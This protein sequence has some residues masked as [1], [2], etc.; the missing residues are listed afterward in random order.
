MSNEISTWER[1]SA[2]YKGKKKKKKIRPLKN[3]IFN[4]S[5]AKV[6]EDCDFGLPESI[7][8]IS[9]E[10]KISPPQSIFCHSL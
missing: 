4:Q 1:E 3:C 10:G 2:A 9:G 6:N 7:R 5:S 8:V